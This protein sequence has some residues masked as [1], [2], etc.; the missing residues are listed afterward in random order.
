ML[1]QYVGNILSSFLLSFFI[2]YYY[3]IYLFSTISLFSFLYYDNLKVGLQYFTYFH[4]TII[5]ESCH[6]ISLFVCVYLYKY[7]CTVV[8]ENKSGCC[9]CYTEVSIYF[10]RTKMYVVYFNCAFLLME[11]INL[12]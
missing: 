3:T 8:K 7:D 2:T 12:L 10:I 5:S 9:K 1:T 4:L 6:H 11:T